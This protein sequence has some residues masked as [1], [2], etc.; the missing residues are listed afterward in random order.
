MQ[1]SRLS[2]KLAARIAGSGLL[3]MTLA[4]TAAFFHFLPQVIVEG[5]NAATL[6][7][8]RDDGGILLVGLL[9][10]IVTYSMDIIVAWALYWFLC[11]EQPALAQLSAWSRLIYTGF[12]FVS[13]F[14][15]FAAHGLVAAP[16]NTSIVSPATLN[17]ELIFQISMAT[18][19]QA[20]ALLIFGIH[21]L[22]LGTT[23]WR[24]IDIPTWVGF[25]VSIAGIAYIVM[26]SANFLAPALQLS[27][28][29]F[30]AMGEAILMLWLLREGWQS[31]ETL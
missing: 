1:T 28:L 11:S 3:I 27:W 12:A 5:D 8:L 20:V 6:A 19:M 30:F 2:R 23:I 26:N 17:A 4:G 10:V 18:T 22:I 25:A 13:L 24:S 14:P 9:L 21:L 16:P 29:A 31:S 7:N 15:L